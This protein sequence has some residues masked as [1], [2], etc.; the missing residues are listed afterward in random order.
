MMEPVVV[1]DFAGPWANSWR[2]TNKILRKE[3][4]NGCKAKLGCK[5]CKGRHTTA[6]WEKEGQRRKN[7]LRRDKLVHLS[8]TLIK[9][10]QFSNPPFVATVSVL[11]CY[12]LI[13]KENQIY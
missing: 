12:K 5:A 4:C 10:L 13:R 7:R 1:L 9:R 6:G 11:I 8:S 3:K 2:K